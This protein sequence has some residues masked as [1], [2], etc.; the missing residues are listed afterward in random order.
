MKLVNQLATTVH[1]VVQE[2]IVV[3]FVREIG[4]ISEIDLFVY[5]SHSN[6]LRIPSDGHIK[7]Y[8]NNDRQTQH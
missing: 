6:V 2:T 5:D 8:S 4:A 3:V 7:K 1:L